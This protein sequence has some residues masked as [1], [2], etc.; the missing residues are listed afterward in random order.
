MI[1][2]NSIFCSPLKGKSA[3]EI[4]RLIEEWVLAYVGTPHIFH[5]DNGREFV[6]QL[7][8]SLL[9]QWSSNN[10]TFVNG[11]PRHSQSQGLVE[12]GNRVIQEKIAAT[13]CEEGYEGKVSFPWASWLP[14]IMFNMNTQWHATT[15]EMA[16]KLVF[17][18]VPRSAL[19]PGASK[20]VVNEEDMNSVISAFPSKEAPTQSSKGEPPCGVL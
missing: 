17:G 7:L 9:D 10:I 3:A 8:H 6:N 12:R 16:Y 18:Q 5:S 11:C 19:V 1:W 13:K 15:K 14:S 20:H 2:Q 4:A